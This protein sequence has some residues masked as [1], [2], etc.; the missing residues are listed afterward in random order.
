[1]VQHG[2]RWLQQTDDLYVEAGAD[3][4]VDWEDLNN[5]PLA[6]VRY[7]GSSPLQRWFHL[8][9]LPPPP[10]RWSE[11]NVKTLRQS[12]LTEEQ[13]RELDQYLPSRLDIASPYGCQKS[14]MD[15]RSPLFWA[16]CSLDWSQ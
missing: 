16:A 3:Y 5:V 1:M 11:V 14:L 13:I 12:P 10:P 6:Q 15:P 9:S 4:G 2:V 8:Q 7:S